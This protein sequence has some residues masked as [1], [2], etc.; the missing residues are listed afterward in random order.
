MIPVMRWQRRDMLLGDR[1]PAA[2]EVARTR[3]LK[4][5]FYRR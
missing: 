3:A 4:M 5:P 1:D 2:T